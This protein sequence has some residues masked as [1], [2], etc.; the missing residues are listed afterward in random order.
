M[1]NE[2]S[3]QSDIFDFSNSVTININFGFSPNN[4]PDFTTNLSG[5]TRVVVGNPVDAI[6]GDPLLGNVGSLDGQQDVI[7]TE[8]FFSVSSGSTPF[9]PLITARIGDGV[10]DLTPTPSDSTLPYESLYSAGAIVQQPNNPALANSSF[11]LFIEIQGTPEGTVRTRSPITLTST[12]SLI[13]FP[14]GSGQNSINFTNGDIIPLFTA[15]ADGIF[16][17]GD[18]VEVARLVPGTDG[19]SVTLNLTPQNSNSGE[20][21]TTVFNGSTNSEVLVGTNGVDI[22]YGNGG[23]DYLAG[24]LGD[25]IL[26]SSDGNDVLIGGDGNDLLYGNGGNDYL[27]SGDGND[28]LLGGDGNDVLLSGDG[29]DDLNGGAGDDILNGGKGTNILSGGAGNDGIIGG[30]AVDLMTGSAGND[31][32]FGNDGND[33]LFGDAGNDGLLGAN[34][35]DV[36][37]GG[38]GNDALFGGDGN[39]ALLGESGNDTLFGESGDDILRGGLG[40]DNLTGGVGA[41]QF[42][43]TDLAGDIDFITDFS[44]INDTVVVSAAGFGGGLIANAILQ[45]DQF[46]IG[47]AAVN[48]SNRFIYNTTTGLLSFDADGVGGVGQTPI[49]ALSAGLALTNNNI[50][51]VA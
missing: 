21:E 40:R 28:G 12:S 16:W 17:T 36:L 22:I 3:S 50:F 20:T 33:I 14:L 5:S 42:A 30:D 49:A 43:F 7:Q 9:A 26:V 24:G 44:V 23:N 47:S 13:E 4:L 32:L 37:N 41:D 11:N 18:E 8:M 25:D 38:D 39:D 29:D 10:P 2:F 1:Q 45:A 27:N 19:S 35:N 6:V 46:V 48:A 34:G 15:G 31:G 51:V